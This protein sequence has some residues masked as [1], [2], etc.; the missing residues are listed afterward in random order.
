MALIMLLSIKQGLEDMEHQEKPETVKNV[1]EEV[2]KF[3]ERMKHSLYWSRLRECAEQ[4]KGKVV[5]SSLGGS[6]GYI[7]EL[8]DGLFAV[9]FLKEGRMELMIKD[10]KP[11]EQ[12][13]EWINSEE[14]RYSSNKSSRFVSHTW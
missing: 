13:I 4:I 14:S 2:L 9:C 3:C 8:E 1:T 5:I 11:S 12:E 6:S 10:K 7:L